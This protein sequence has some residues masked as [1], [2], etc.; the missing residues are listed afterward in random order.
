LSQASQILVI[1]FVV[2]NAQLISSLVKEVIIIIREMKEGPFPQQLLKSTG[3]TGAVVLVHG[4]CSS[5][6]PWSAYPADWTNAY[7]FLNAG[8]SLTH[9]AFA[10]LVLQY[11]AQQDL[12]SY[13]IVGHSQ[14]GIVG[15]HILNF[16]NSGMDLINGSPTSRK[17]Q[18][19]GTPFKGCTGAGSSANLA[20]SFGVGCGSNFDLS[21]DGSKLWEPTI[22]DA[23]R[24]QI[25]FYTT[26]YELG[27][28]FGDYCNMAVNMV[29]EWPNDGVS[30]LEYARMNLAKDMGNTEKQCHTTDMSYTAQYYDHN[31]NRNMNSLAGRA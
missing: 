26:T 19:L 24:T 20:K 30:E 31:R 6:N 28:F 23:T 9:D 18:S 4:Y 3:V 17:V 10:K 7:Y 12:T 11:A 1:M 21:L 25:Y 15:A 14:G 13:S 22:R 2:I 27:N 5:T 29:L 16:Y 8:A